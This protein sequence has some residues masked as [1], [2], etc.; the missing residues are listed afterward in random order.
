[1]ETGG[2]FFSSRS[3]IH[4][5]LGSDEADQVNIVSRTVVHGDV[6][7]K[8]TTGEFL[9][10]ICNSTIRGN[11]QLIENESKIA[12]GTDPPCLAGVAVGGNLKAF[13][14]IGELDFSYNTIGGDLQCKENA[15]VPTGWDNTVDG[16]KEGQCSGFELDLFAGLG[17]FDIR[18]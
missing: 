5:D 18:I 9:T 15:L 2:A 8:K 14:N 1:M 11:L 16:N 10:E 6:Q 4:G 3:T 17:P 12:V 13:K 7:V